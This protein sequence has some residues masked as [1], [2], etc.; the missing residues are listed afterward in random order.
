MSYSKACCTLPPVASDYTPIGSIE[1]LGDLSVYTVGPK[2][3]TKAVFVFYDIFG[4]HVN[5]KQFC[6]ILAKN[7]GWKVVMP[8]FFRGKPLVESDLGDIPKLLAWVDK[9]GTAEVVTPDVI[10][11]Q[12]HLKQQGVTAATFV[13]FCWGAKI[14]VQLTSTLPFFVGAA[15]IHPSFVD[16]KDAETA[17]APIL[18]V[19]SE[20]EPDMV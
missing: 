14:A 5:T 19:P 18:N 16:V 12:E 4:F 13:G 15:C 10:R 17:G 8:D 7:C 9:N 6:D 11:V 1:N 2:D 3:A 20:D